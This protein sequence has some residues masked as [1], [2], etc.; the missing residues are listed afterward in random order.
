L[1]DIRGHLN[2]RDMSD[3]EASAPLYPV[4]YAYAGG[5]NSNVTDEV[6]QKVR[7]AHG[8]R[9]KRKKTSV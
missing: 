1:H 3:S 8:T 9:G 7:F 4:R 6:V 5:K 2:T